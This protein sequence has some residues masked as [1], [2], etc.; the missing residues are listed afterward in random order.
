MSQVICSSCFEFKDTT[1]RCI[2]LPYICDL[3]E[4][5]S[6]LAIEQDTYNSVVPCQSALN[7][8]QEEQYLDP[9][10]HE[11]DDFLTTGYRAAHDS[12]ILDQF[13]ADTELIN[14]LRE[15][16][17]EAHASNASLT[18][19]IEFCDKR[20][21]AYQQVAAEADKFA[22]ENEKEIRRLKELLDNNSI[23][24]RHLELRD[25]NASLRSMLKDKTREAKAYEL[26]YERASRSLW[27][28]ITDWFE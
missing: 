1:K 16:L 10:K 21:R 12:D 19:E 8:V 15:Q 5:D 27:E 6:A 11:I 13:N 3:C 26:A 28:R 23:H 17:D 25:E 7:S 22:M 2:E 9:I 4:K 14:D 24:L 20:V 18:E